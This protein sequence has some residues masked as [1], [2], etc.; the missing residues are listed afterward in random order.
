M[1]KKLRFK[2]GRLVYDFDDDAEY[3][4]AKKLALSGKFDD[5]NKF[6]SGMTDLAV[7]SP[8]E[9]IPEVESVKNELLE[10]IDPTR[11]SGSDSSA[12]Q[13]GL[14]EL[15]D[16][17]TP[18][19]LAGIT[20]AVG[21]SGLSKAF[22]VPKK[23][24]KKTD[25]GGGLLVDGPVPNKKPFKKLV[26]MVDSNGK[27]PKAKLPSSEGSLKPFP[28]YAGK[29]LS[30]GAAF[31]D[32]D[33][34]LKLSPEAG[35]LKIPDKSSRARAMI[36]KSGGKNIQYDEK[37]KI[38][39][40]T[41]GKEQ[42]EAN[43]N[44]RFGTR[45]LG[46]SPRQLGT[47]DR[48]LGTNERS[49]LSKIIKGE[50]PSTGRGYSKE[51][52]AK[53]DEAKSSL[54]DLPGYEKERGAY[55]KPQAIPAVS[56]KGK[57][58][59][60]TKLNNVDLN[61]SNDFDKAAYTL[62]SGKPNNALLREIAKQT[63]LD[64]KVI[65]AHGTRLRSQAAKGV[66]KLPS[67]SSSYDVAPKRIF[68][69]GEE[70]ER[71]S[72]GKELLQLPSQLKFG[73]DLPAMR[74]S[75]RPFLLHPVKSGL[76]ALKNAFKA[77][78]EKGYREVLDDM[79]TQSPVYK[80]LGEYKALPADT[81]KLYPN[82]GTLDKLPS[83]DLD[84][85][86]LPDS[87]LADLPLIGSHYV[88]PSNRMFDA[89]QKTIRGKEV[90]RLAPNL[91]ELLAGGPDEARTLEQIINRVSD[92][93]GHGTLGELGDK[94]VPYLNNVFTAPRNLAAKTQFYNPL[95]YIPENWLNKGGLGVLNKA[96]RNIGGTGDVA[97]QDFIKDQAKLLAGQGAG[98][99]AA[100]Q[101]GADVDVD[102]FSSNFGVRFGDYKPDLFGGEMGIV[103]EGAR[104]ASA[105]PLRR[106]SRG[107]EYEGTPIDED[108]KFLRG[109]L[110]PGAPSML[111]DWRN[112]N[113][114][115]GAR[116]NWLGEDIS[117]PYVEGTPE[118]DIAHTLMGDVAD[119]PY[120]R[121]LAQQITP[122]YPGDIIDA[123]SEGLPT[124][125]A[126]TMLGALGSGG[127]TYDP[128]EMNPYRAPKKVIK[129][130]R[131]KPGEYERKHSKPSGS[132]S[133]GGSGWTVIN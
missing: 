10:T 19:S 124:A 122:A 102:P 9:A 45:N 86:F 114:D 112:Y 111:F 126:A 25:I 128:F 85:Y 74:Q 83:S 20:G 32:L 110:R 127:S 39:R 62:A 13:G 108:I 97:Y 44:E 104:L 48:Q 79:S 90:E 70:V 11:G 103:R 50:D 8:F 16:T 3:E 107:K 82:I 89:F 56:I 95:N 69:P 53:I 7:H 120:S 84:A 33:T 17:I 12:L 131:R 133:K 43:L 109:R 41:K 46:T 49:P 100:S 59:Y 37:S 21:G 132:D 14:A 5:K 28:D 92:E 101:A 91:D 47:S 24:P 78:S 66:T 118:G 72:W 64:E 98:L 125:L 61:F 1:P 94:A 93:T 38:I 23:I 27:A 58:R 106:S 60:D 29:E 2:N 4:S 35:V 80:R 30:E 26:D 6:E 117:K 22:G 71:P 77:R 36:E 76:P 75:Y 65:L 116:E 34:P 123:S 18:T 40:W 113:P 88:K 52:Q 51:S 99:Y 81:E 57:Y 55:G 54:G 15:L 67:G 105:S 129:I 115:T 42:F 73:G 68:G 130:K 31:K 121:W 119:E 63:G 87:R 96:R